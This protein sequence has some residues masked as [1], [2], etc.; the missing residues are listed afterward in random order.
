MGWTW[1]MNKN[2]P[3]GQLT[4]EPKV[5]RVVSMQKQ[6]E[7]IQKK[8]NMLKLMIRADKRKVST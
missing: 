3:I 1:Q 7:Q 6:K 4:E 2:L 5:D 8:Q